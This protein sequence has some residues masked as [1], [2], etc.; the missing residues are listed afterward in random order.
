MSTVNWT[1][2]AGGVTKSLVDWGIRDLRVTFKSLDV[3]EMRF[4]IPTPDVTAAE[5][6]AYGEQLILWRNDVCWFSGWVSRLPS[7]ATG[8]SEKYGYIVSG[9]WWQLQRIIYQ[10][11]SLY[12]NTAFNCLVGQM[13]PRVVL[14]QDPWGNKLSSDGQIFDIC[15]FSQLKGSGMMGFGEIPSLA[16]MILEECKDISCAEA[17][18]RCLKW[19]P[20]ASSWFDYSVEVPT[21]YIQQRPFNITTVLD[22]ANKN[23]IK[24]TERITPRYDLRPTGVVFNYLTSVIQSNGVQTYICT[25][26]S[27]GAGDTEAGAIVACMELSGLGGGTPEAAPMGLASTFFNALYTYLYWEGAITTHEQD[28]TGQL[29]PGHSLNLL[30]GRPAWANMYTPIQVVTEDIDHGITEASFGPPEH[31]APQDFFTLMMWLRNLA[32]TSTWPQTM[33]NGTQG[34]LSCAAP[35]PTTYGN[36]QTALINWYNNPTMAN[37]LAVQQAALAANGISAQPGVPT[38]TPNKGGAG[39]KNIGGMTSPKNQI[40]NYGS[41]ACVDCSG[42]PHTVVTM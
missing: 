6:F 2:S 27:A 36:L 20:D 7:I 17:I 22:L 41:W 9:P 32:T 28:C 8:A 18:K 21:M 37:W 10:Q 11:W 30:N 42:N 23:L 19:T 35:D 14:G 1:L 15:V 12:W 3:D 5:P 16:P 29:R 33:H 4:N 13:T 40:N 39:G 26:D 31:L 24:G 25:K 38:P 34:I